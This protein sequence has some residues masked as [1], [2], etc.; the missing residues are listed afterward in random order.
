MENNITIFLDFF[1]QIINVNGVVWSLH[2][3]CEIVLSS[4]LQQTKLKA[5]NF[6]FLAL[7]IENLNLQKR[8]QP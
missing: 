3:F 7:K 1:I 4:S 5:K 2:D 6:R 8:F